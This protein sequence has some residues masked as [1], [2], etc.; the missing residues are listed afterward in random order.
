MAHNPPREWITNEQLRAV[1]ADANR[2]LAQWHSLDD[3]ADKMLE[4]AL[5]GKRVVLS[6][7][8]AEVVGRWVKGKINERQS[9]AT[10]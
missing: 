1:A 9:D 3:L 7:G 4:R 5:A 6:P 2:K 10:K 8:M